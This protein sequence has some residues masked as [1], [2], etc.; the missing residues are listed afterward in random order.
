MRFNKSTCA[1]TISALA[2]ASL[3]GD[4]DAFRASPHHEDFNSASGYVIRDIDGERCHALDWDGLPGIESILREKGLRSHALWTQFRLWRSEHH[5][6]SLRDAGTKACEVLIKVFGP[7]DRATAAALE[8]RRSVSRERQKILSKLD[9]EY[10]AMLRCA[11]REYL[12]PE[13][14]LTLTLPTFPPILG[15]NLQSLGAPPT[16]QVH[17]DIVFESELFGSVS[18]AEHVL[19]HYMT[20]ASDPLQASSV[21]EFAKGVLDK[22]KP[23]EV[24][25]EMLEIQESLM[26]L[27]AIPGEGEPADMDQIS[28]GSLICRHRAVVVG[29]VLADAGFNIEVVRG[30]I[31]QDGRRGGHL[32]LYS[33]LEGILEPSS[34]GPEY[35]KEVVSVYYEGG[36]MLVQVKGGALYRL[37]HR[38]RLERH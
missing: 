13:I 33:E 18:R 20:S 8:A 31:E 34:D 23:V 3:P 35:W 21:G 37:D 29:I 5:D 26:R 27:P 25:L 6:S 11:A 30:S 9:Q 38:T 19:R 24:E 32:F 15:V 17:R 2:L 10:P 16:D 22:I 7:Y 1:S 12:A 28:F 4:R 14:S 36:A